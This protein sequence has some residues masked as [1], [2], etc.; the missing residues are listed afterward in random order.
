MKIFPALSA[1]H[2]A[3]NTQITCAAYRDGKASTVPHK[4]SQSTAPYAGQTIS[5]DTIGPITPP[6]KPGHW[7]IATF[8]EMP[9]PYAFVHS[10]HTRKKIETIL[11]QDLNEIMHRSQLR[12]HRLH[13]DNAREYLSTQIKTYLMHNVISKTTTIRYTPQSNEILDRLNHRLINVARAALSHSRL[14]PTYW[15]HALSDATFKY[16]HTPH[17]YTGMTPAQKW[18]P[19]IAPPP[20]LLPFGTIV[21]VPELL[22]K[23][24]LQPRS[25]PTRFLTHI[26]HREILILLTDTNFTALA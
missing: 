14:P 13:Y 3:P 11:P 21:T 1:L 16:N 6:S 26:T 15:H 5:S 18:S 10:I 12:I 4:T 22:P 24:Q 19:N 20:Y 8:I 7:H 17:I 23:Q 2:I 9:S 25:R